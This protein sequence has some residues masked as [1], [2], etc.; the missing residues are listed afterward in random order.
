MVAIANPPGIRPTRAL[1]TW[2]ILRAMSPADITDPAKIKKGTAKT[3][4]LSAPLKICW[5]KIN[6]EVSVKKKSD[7]PVE[8]SIEIE[9]GTPITNSNVNKNIV[10]TIIRFQPFFYLKP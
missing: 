6:K 10:K 3:T 8:I 1:I 4:K 7:R 2:T 5:G 9:I